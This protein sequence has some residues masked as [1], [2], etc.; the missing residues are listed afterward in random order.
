MKPP[1][2]IGP[3]HFVRIGCVGMSGITEML[4]N[5]G[6]KGANYANKAN[7]KWPREMALRSRSGAANIEAERM[8]GAGDGHSVMPVREFGLG[9]MR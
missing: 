5:L 8:C 2:D 7:V 6:M 3:I 1:R 4:D 9:C